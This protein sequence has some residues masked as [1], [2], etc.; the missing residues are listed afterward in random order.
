MMS[1]LLIN[2]MTRVMIFTSLSR[3]LIREKRVDRQTVEKLD[4]VVLVLSAQ[5]DTFSSG[6]GLMF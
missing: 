3:E 2:F 5:E 4:F 1:I 6:S